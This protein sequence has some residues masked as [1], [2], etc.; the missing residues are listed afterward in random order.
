MSE[1]CLTVVYYRGS[2]YVCTPAG[3]RRWLYA[4]YREEYIRT[5]SEEALAEMLTFVDLPAE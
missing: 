4:R 1:D 5:G 2:G 3:G